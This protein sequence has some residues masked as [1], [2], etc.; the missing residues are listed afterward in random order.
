MAL[1]AKQG[2]RLIQNPDTLV[3]SFLEAN[4]GRKP[5]YAWRSIWNS[6]KLLQEGVIWRVGDGAN[7]RIWDDLRL[8]NPRAH[9]ACSPVNILGRNA[10]VS[11]LMD[12]HTNW[13]NIT[14]VKEVFNEEEA[15]M[16]CN[17][18]LNP[19]RGKDRLAWE[20]SKNGMFTVRSAYHLAVERFGKEEGICS[21]VHQKQA[22]WK[23]I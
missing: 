15:S 10:K 5:Y 23:Q 19:L 22:L 17:L 11:E 13:W 21:T 8:P 20:H 4:I 12:V 18:G 7:V 1:L 2:W 9:A 16:I 14:L 3:G 6:N